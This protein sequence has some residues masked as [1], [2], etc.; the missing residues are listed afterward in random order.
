MTRPFALDP[1]AILVGVVAGAVITAVTAAL[2][3]RR[4]GK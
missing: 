4:H 3:T 2:L 1:L